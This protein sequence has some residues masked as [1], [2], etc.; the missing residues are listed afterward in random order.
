MISNRHRLVLLSDC[1]RFRCRG[2][3]GSGGAR[4]GSD[5]IRIP[6][7]TCTLPNG[8][9]VILSVDKSTPTVAVKHTSSNT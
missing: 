8:L 7:G 2:C 9:N 3:P 4:D 5:G 1:S 6:F